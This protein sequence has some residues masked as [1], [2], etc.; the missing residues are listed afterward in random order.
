[1]SR[2]A[3]GPATEDDTNTRGYD[4]AKRRQRTTGGRSG[5]LI[6]QFLQLVFRIVV[7]PT[8][9]SEQKSQGVPEWVKNNA[10]WWANGDIDD[11]SFVQGIQF[12][13]KSGLISIGSTQESVEET[14]S[15]SNNELVKLEYLAIK[16]YNL[17]WYKFL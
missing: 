16:R 13:I 10:A 5:H 17:K 7:P 8:Q 14:K 4:L 6:N 3:R 15:S 12:M 9:V 2:F 11:D 1:M